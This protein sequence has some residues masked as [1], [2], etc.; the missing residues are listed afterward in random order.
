MGFRVRV[1][2]LGL[3][4]DLVVFAAAAKLDHNLLKGAVE[5]QPLARVGVELVVHVHRLGQLRHH[6]L[7]G[8][9]GD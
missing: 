9:V 8:E 6:L 1:W 3:R 5:D 2:S 7:L 4:A